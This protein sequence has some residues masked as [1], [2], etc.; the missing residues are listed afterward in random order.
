MGQLSWRTAIILAQ[1]RPTPMSISRP[2]HGA[3]VTRNVRTVSAVIRP[4]ISVARLSN[5]GPAPVVSEC[6]SHD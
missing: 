1:R 4:A 6:V 3:R 2:I 5:A